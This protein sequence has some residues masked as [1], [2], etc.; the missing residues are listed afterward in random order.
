MDIFKK[1]GGGEML[2]SGSYH[3][4]SGIYYY[5][6]VLVSCILWHINLYGLFNSK[7]CLYIYIIYMI[8]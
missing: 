6:A 5:Y 3:V 2:Y 8:C 1:F 4:T 7:S